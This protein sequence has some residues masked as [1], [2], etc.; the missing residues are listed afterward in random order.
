[1]WARTR[2]CVNASARV[3]VMHACM[4]SHACMIM[5]RREIMYA[6]LRV[7]VRVY[8]CVC[9]GERVHTTPHTVTFTTTRI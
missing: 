1:M 5:C 3:S 2:M 8:V 9:M 7:H 4:C 6:G